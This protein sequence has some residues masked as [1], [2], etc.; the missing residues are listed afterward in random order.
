MLHRLITSLRLLWRKR[1]GVMPLRDSLVPLGEWFDSPM[2][3][4]ILAREQEV[5]DRQ[6]PDLFGYHLLQLSVSDHLVLSETSRISHRFAMHPQIGPDATLSALADFNHL[7]LPPGSIDLVLL[8]HVLDYSQ[9]PHQALREAAATLISQGHLVIIGFNPWSMLGLWRW[10][11]R[12]FSRAPQWRHQSLRLGRVLDWLELL[13]FEP[14][15][16]CQ[17]VYCPPLQHQNAMKYLQWM[18]RWGKRLGLPG[19]GSYLIVARKDTAAF[20]PLK[21]QWQT[22]PGLRAWGV[23]KILGRSTRHGRVIVKPFRMVN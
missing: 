9:S 15:H 3:Q 21:P 10:L 19:G 2:G 4:L 12:W 20:T 14:V 23:T 8:H 17:C 18:D 22:Y 16:V 7:P 1:F 13:D 5:I 11:A 6:L